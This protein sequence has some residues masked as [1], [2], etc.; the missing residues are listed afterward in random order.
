MKNNKLKYYLLIV[1]AGILSGAI[2]FGG[3]VFSLL[4]LSLFEISIWTYLIGLVPVFFILL[5]QKKIL[6]RKDMIFIFLLYGFLTAIT[7]MG[8]FS[9]VIL[10]LPIAIAVLLLYTQPL[11]T[12]IYAGIFMK[13]KISFLEVF[14]CFLVLLGVL[15]LVNPWGSFHITSWLG[16][17]AGLVRGIGLSGWILTSNAASKK[18]NE[19]TNTFFWGSISLLFFLFIFL[20]FSRL[21]VSDPAIVRFGLDFPLYLWIYL[22]LFSLFTNVIC[23]I[24]FFYGVKV[25]SAVDSSLV[26]LVEP[27]VGTILAALFLSQAITFSVFIGGMLILLANYLIIRKGS[28]ASEL[29]ETLT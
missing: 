10:G 22:A 6:L 19:P 1:F 17:I 2:V 25:V 28:G 23:H 15:F 9:S 13:E 8:Q 14:C 26:M 27:V 16:F 7:V 5:L 11:W 18:G 20:P 21:F 24:S 29:S 4:G 3:K 12:I